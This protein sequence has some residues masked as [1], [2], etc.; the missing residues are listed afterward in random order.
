ME[1]ISSDIRAAP[2]QEVLTVSGRQEFQPYILRYQRVTLRPG[3][4]IVFTNLDAP[5]YVVA[6]EVLQLPDPSAYVEIALAESERDLT[7]Q[8]GAAGSNGS[9]GDPGG[10]GE[11]AGTAARAARLTSRGSCS[12]WAVS[13]VP[14]EF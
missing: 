11:R 8:R 7:G 9:D 12:S 2:L 1:K 13:K 14:T 5:Y 4:Q 3:T 10:Q 6:A